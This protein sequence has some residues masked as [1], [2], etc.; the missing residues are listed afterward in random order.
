[1]A[2]QKLSLYKI[3]STD[4]EIC[5]HMRRYDQS[6]VEGFPEL[7]YFTVDLDDIINEPLKPV[8]SRLYRLIEQHAMNPDYTVDVPLYVLTDA[9]GKYIGHLSG[10]LSMREM[11]TNLRSLLQEVL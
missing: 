4:C 2:T 10:E 5:E 9:E 3:F 8:N 7:K 11:R 1:M 6:V